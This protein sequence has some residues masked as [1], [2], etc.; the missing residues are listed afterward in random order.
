MGGYGTFEL[1]AR[2]PDTFAAIAPLSGGANPEIAPRLKKM[3]AWIFHGAEDDV[4]PTLYSTNVAAAMQKAGAPV[5]LTVYPGVGHGDWD[6]T[7]S[8]PALYAWFLE[9]SK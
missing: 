9:H 8:D 3:P 7:Y 6:K 4:V 1:A 2:Y 5:K